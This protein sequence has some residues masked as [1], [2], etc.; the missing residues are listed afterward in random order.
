LFFFFESNAYARQL[1]YFFLSE[2]LA[3]HFS[4]SGIAAFF[5]IF[6]SLVRRLTRF[7]FCSSVS[8][9]ASAEQVSG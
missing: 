3:C 5:V 6:S 4:P 1:T 7:P 2:Q 9:W 8:Q